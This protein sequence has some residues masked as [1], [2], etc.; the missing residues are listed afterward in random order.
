MMRDVEEEADH[1]VIPEA[2]AEDKAQE[3]LLG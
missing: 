2:G 1:Q 3:P